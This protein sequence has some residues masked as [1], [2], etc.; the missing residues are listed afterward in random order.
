MVRLVIIV[1]N[2]FSPPSLC[3]ESG[4]VADHQTRVDPDQKQSGRPAGQPGAHGE[5]PQQE[6]GYA[7]ELLLN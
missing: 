6:V 3:S 5:G 2:T 1:S 4:R 7:A